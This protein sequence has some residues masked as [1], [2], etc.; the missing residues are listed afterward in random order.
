MDITCERCGTT[1]RA[2]RSTRRFCDDCSSKTYLDRPPIEREC[3]WCGQPFTIPRGSNK[4]EAGRR[5]CCDE[6]AREGARRS[7][8]ES[9][10]RRGRGEPKR[11][12]GRPATLTNEERQQRKREGV[13][14]RFFRLH[15]HRPKVCEAC[16]E[17]RIV[18][19]AHKKP[20]E[21]R[22]RSGKNTRDEDVW[23]LCPTC[24]RCL[25]LGIQTKEELGIA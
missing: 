25:D 17:D 10:I 7:R 16:G 22:W 13:K 20:R 15:P 18:E 23:V 11:R 6:H 24:H 1:V 21:G 4:V 14:D 2:L 8:R 9:A 12:E 3:H 5:Y 19:L